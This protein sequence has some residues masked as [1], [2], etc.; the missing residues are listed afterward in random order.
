MS[1]RRR[2]SPMISSPAKQRNR[3]PNNPPT[4]PIRNRL[5]CFLKPGAAVEI[6][7]SEG[8]Y[9]GSWF[10]GK[11]LTLPSSDKDSSKCQVEY[12]TMSEV[13]DGSKLLREFV[14][15]DHLRPRPPP[16]SEKER[17]RDIAV[18]EDVDAY[19]NDVWWEGTVTEVC[20]DGKFSVFFRASRE[21]IQFRRDEL[22]FHREWVNDTWKPPLDETEEEEEEEEESEEEDEVDDDTE[23]KEY[24]VPQVDPETTRAIAKEMFSNGTVVEVSSDEEG[25]VGCWFAARIVERIGEDKYMIEYKDLREDNGV[26]PLKEEADFLHI[27]PPPPSDEDLDFS[28][29]DKIDAF[30]NDGW[31]V[32]EVMES[33]KDGSVGIFFRE[34][35]EKMRFGRQGLRLH[36]EWVNGTWELPLKKGEMKRTKKLPCERNVRPKIAT[37]KQYFSIGTP[38]EV[39][40]IEEG[41]EDSW[42]L[43]KLVEYRGT[44]KCLVE[45]DKLKDEDGKEPLREEVNVFQIRPQ[46]LEM[47]MVNPFEKLDKVNA[48]YND[49]WWIGVVKKVLAKSSYLVHFSRTDEMLKFHH[50]QLRLHEEWVDGKWIASSKCQTA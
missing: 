13:G 10:P 9:R 45:Y 26:E 18:G 21:Q 25:F 50:S 20:S 47:V 14:H 23:D 6:S 3:A 32:G 17:K 43:A 15:V 28:V 1:S 7:T 37:D 11:L 35:R 16:M 36:K 22:R 8:D 46:P 29:G 2:Q 12:A 4:R 49:G 30:Y 5:P 44:D 34:S 39:G 27:R 40:S 38:V 33:V 31:W 42:F 24:L 19:Y 48:L 41:F